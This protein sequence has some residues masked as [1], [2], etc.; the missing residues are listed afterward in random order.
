MDLKAPP[1]KI[2]LILMSTF[3]LGYTFGY[4]M[5]KKSEESIIP[6]ITAHVIINM[7][8]ILF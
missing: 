5:H 1:L 8:S 2:I 3:L 4:V 7:I 6:I